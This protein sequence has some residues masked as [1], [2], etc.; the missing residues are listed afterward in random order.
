MNQII[1]SD[2]AYLSYEDISNYLI[3]KFSLDTAL[4]FDNEV[5]QLCEKLILF[6]KSCP[7]YP[8]RPQLRSCKV[9]KY[10][11][12]IYRIDGNKIHLITF[13]D[14]RSIHHF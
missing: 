4:K 13:Y 14:N 10:I 7:S 9:N 1:W 3:L 6:N 2:L 5:E 11:S 12:L 8:P